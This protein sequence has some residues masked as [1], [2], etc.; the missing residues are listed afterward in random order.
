MIAIGISLLF[1]VAAFASLMVIRQSV[2]RAM[3]VQQEIRAELAGLDSLAARQRLMPAA[4]AVDRAFTLRAAWSR[5]VVRPV[6][7]AVAPSPCVAA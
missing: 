6:A 4:R 1:S 5:P 7:W 3:L 2:E